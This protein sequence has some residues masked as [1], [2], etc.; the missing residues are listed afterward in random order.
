MAIGSLNDLYRE[1][2]QEHPEVS[3]IDLNGYM[4]PGGEFSDLYVDG[5]RLRSDGVHFTEDGA[6]IVARWLAPQI[7]AIAEGQ[8]AG[9]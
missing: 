8:T 2:A 1:Y 4:C 9:G 3:I 5:V 6:P 7:T